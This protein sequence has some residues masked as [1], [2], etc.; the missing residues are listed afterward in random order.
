MLYKREN[1]CKNLTELEARLRTHFLQID[2]IVIINVKL[3]E[4]ETIFAL[5][6]P[7]YIKQ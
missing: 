7:T 2:V 3:Y 4:T 1:K 5:V 6:L